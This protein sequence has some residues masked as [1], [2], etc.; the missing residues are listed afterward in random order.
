MKTEN[1]DNRMI[2]KLK[3]YLGIRSPSDVCIT[4][5]TG[6]SSLETTRDEGRNGTMTKNRYKQNEY[7]YKRSLRVSLLDI[8][9]E[10]LRA[11]SKIINDSNKVDFYNHGKTLKYSIAH[12]IYSLA[13]YA[14]KTDIIWYDEMLKIYK[15]TNKLS[16]QY[17]DFETAVKEISDIFNRNDLNDY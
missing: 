6:H 11:L 14:C 3:K 13:E 12:D 4:Y 10:K 7:L 2:I 16:W 17:I 1:N 9:Y 15:M 5:L 8:I